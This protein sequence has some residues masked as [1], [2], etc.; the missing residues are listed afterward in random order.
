MT[1]RALPFTHRPVP[2]MLF[3]MSAILE[4]LRDCKVS[5]FAA[6]EVVLGQGSTTGRLYFLIRGAVEVV[7]DDGLYR[8][9]KGEQSFY[10]V[11]SYAF[12]PQDP[13]CV[14]AWCQHGERFAA[15]VEIGNIFATQFHPEKSQKCGLAVLRNFISAC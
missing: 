3:P 10:F 13:S 2:A 9:A 12:C 6:G 4:Q 1:G 5:H 7:K 14:S 11:H 15:S 8:G